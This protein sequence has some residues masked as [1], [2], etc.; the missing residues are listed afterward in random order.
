MPPQHGIKPQLLKLRTLI[1]ELKENASYNAQRNALDSLK[2]Q[3]D[4]NGQLILF[5]SNITRR[6]SS[7]SSSTRLI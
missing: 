1:P 2:D 3:R 6:V 7:L 4:A 5:S